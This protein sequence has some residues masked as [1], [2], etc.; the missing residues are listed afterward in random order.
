MYPLSQRA[1]QIPFFK[2]NDSIIVKNSWWLKNPY[3]LS[4]ANIGSK[5]KLVLTELKDKETKPEYYIPLGEKYHSPYGLSQF[6]NDMYLTGIYL[7]EESKS[8]VRFFS[9]GKLDG[10]PG[11]NEYEIHVF[12]YGITKY[13]RITLR[14]KDKTIKDLKVFHRRKGGKNIALYSLSDESPDAKI[15]GV[16]MKLK[17][18]E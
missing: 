5:T 9:D 7:S 8:K 15:E 4:I 12:R 10:I 14:N 1:E 16:Y 17:F 13:N 11:Y 2:S 18:I 6:I 3:T